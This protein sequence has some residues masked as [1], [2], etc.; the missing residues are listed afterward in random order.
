MRL[1]VGVNGAFTHMS[2]FVAVNDIQMFEVTRQS[3][4]KTVLNSSADRRFHNWLATAK[5]ILFRAVMSECDIT[6]AELAAP[7][8]E[9]PVDLLGWFA[10]FT[11]EKTLA[12]VGCRVPA[13]AAADQ[14]LVHRWHERPIELGRR[15][16]DGGARETDPA[17]CWCLQR[18]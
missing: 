6:A 7:H 17:L 12:F 4:M 11:M 18:P 8:H 1:S 5:I 14:N 10:D 15:G 9:L 3:M 2:C 13:A 16:R